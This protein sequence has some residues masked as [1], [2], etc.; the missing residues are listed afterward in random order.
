MPRPLPRLRLALT[1][2]VWGV[3]GGVVLFWVYAPTLTAVARRWGQ[4]PNYSHG[5][6]VPL[7]AAFLLWPRRGLLRSSPDRGGF[8]FEDLSAKTRAGRRRRCSL[9]S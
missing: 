3:I 4:D 9:S 2:S 6:L 5:Y 8:I 7:F 1:P